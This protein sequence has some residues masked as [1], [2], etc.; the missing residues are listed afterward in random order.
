MFYVVD[1]ILYFVNQNNDDDNNLI[2]LSFNKPICESG[3]MK[4]NVST[5]TKNREK[6]NHFTAINSN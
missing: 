5:K 4:W 2:F 3:M 6:N 1:W